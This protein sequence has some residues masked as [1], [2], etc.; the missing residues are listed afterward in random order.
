MSGKTGAREF[1][2]FEK[3]LHARLMGAEREIV[4][5]VMSAS[6]VEA[7]AIEI[8]GRVHRRATCAERNTSSSMI[9]SF[10]ATGPKE[11]TPIMRRSSSHRRA[12]LASSS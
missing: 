3:A 7:D 4:G 9:A 12:T 5:S 1:Y 8:E 11:A 10:L 2:E 6:D